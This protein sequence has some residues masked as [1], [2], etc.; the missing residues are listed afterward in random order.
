MEIFN[1]LAKA[2]GANSNTRQFPI[3]CD[4]AE[5]RGT[6]VVG[7]AFRS[8]NFLTVQYILLCSHSTEFVKIVLDFVLRS[9]VVYYIILRSKIWEKS[10]MV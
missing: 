7:R 5:K 10:V 2:I 1:R 8:V 6:Y 4:E 9:K 3:T